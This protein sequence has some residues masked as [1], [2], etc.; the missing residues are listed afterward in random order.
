MKDVLHITVGGGGGL[1]RTAA[2]LTRE[3]SAADEIAGRTAPVTIAQFLFWGAG[4]LALI[5]FV[6]DL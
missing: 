6:M 4:V 1:L 3:R 2:V 5:V